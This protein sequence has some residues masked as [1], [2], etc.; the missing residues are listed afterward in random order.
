MNR[1]IDMHCFRALQRFT[2][3][4]TQSCMNSGQSNG[5][6]TRR[7]RR[8][9]RAGR[10]VIRRI[11]CIV[12]NRPE[13][14]LHRGCGVTYTNLV[15]IQ[16]NE[17]QISARVTIREKVHSDKEPSGINFANLKR[18]EFGINLPRGPSLLSLCTLNCRSMK[19]KASSLC[20]YV[21]S[22][23][24]D[25]LAL[26]ETWLGTDLDNGVINETVPQGYGIAHV[27]RLEKRGGGI[28]VIFN[29]GLDVKH[30][31]NTDS[32][33]HFEH[34]ECTVKNKGIGFRL[35]VIYRPPPSKGNE[36]RRSVFFDEWSRLLDRLAVLPENLVI[37]GDL[38]FHLDNLEDRDT[39]TLLSYLD[40]HGLSQ[41]VSG[42]THI[43]G[44]TLDVVITRERGSLLFS[45]PTIEDPLLSDSKG[46]KSG[47]HF[48]IRSELHLSKP[49]RTRKAVSFRRYNKI[50]MSD[51][52]Q[53]LQS[54]LRNVDGS[55]NEQ[56]NAYDSDI[57]D[58]I[59]KHA[60]LV[61]KEIILRPSS[62]WY[63]DELRASK[64]ERRKAERR[65]RRTK[66]TV[67]REMFVDVCQR[68]NK[69]LLDAKKQFY[70]DKVEGYGND[71]K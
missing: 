36:F 6:V 14:A 9:T 55:A 43:R 19:N 10:N 54:S 62:P 63:T 60:P 12:F 25:I 37:T 26:T 46:N 71:P 53:D 13:D 34:M 15:Q 4:I 2:N 70:R 48:A 11:K 59:N 47:D 28:A 8:G 40:A 42:A 1:A 49:Q 24:L 38:N 18:V 35:C 64:R 33:T 52:K 23:N 20:D 45:P 39:K 65:W 30:Q 41:N 29:K 66:L 32:F 58:F 51:L 27:P 21:T 31:V 68:S 44:H 57:R 22:N 69:L 17:L 50:V 7:T 5:Y 67:H 56:A 16:A 61:T 3:V